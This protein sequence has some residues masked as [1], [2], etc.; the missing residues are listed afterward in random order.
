VKDLQEMR[1]R[2][3]I[4]VA[5]D[6]KDENVFEVSFMVIEW[7]DVKGYFRTHAT[8]LPGAATFGKAL[9]HFTEVRP[10]MQNRDWTKMTTPSWSRAAAR[11]RCW[12]R[13][14]GAHLVNSAM[15]MTPRPEHTTHDIAYA[16]MPAMN[17]SVRGVARAA[18]RQWL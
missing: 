4:W 17:G 5:M 14:R 8:D 2:I 9:G 12:R 16:M 18:A 15:N 13:L 11:T 10:R 6:I 1:H 3:M 7:V